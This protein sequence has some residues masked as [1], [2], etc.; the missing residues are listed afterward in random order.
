[1][2]FDVKKLDFQSDLTH[3]N[4][5]EDDELGL[6]A[7]IHNEA[8]QYQKERL[9][10]T[11]LFYEGDKIVGYITVAMDSIKPKL[12]GLRIDNFEKANYPA[13]LLGRL[14]VAN[15]ERGK[16]IG[17]YLIKYC[18]LLALEES[19]RCGC[20]FIVLVTKGQRRIKFYEDNGFKKT[21]IQ[22]KDGLKLMRFN[23][24]KA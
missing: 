4:C 22:L 16:H 1:M 12:S 20:R 11:Y 24:G 10:V 5:N 7:F 17:S 19:K 23:L 2:V 6:H 15:T 14:A 13:L 9:G 18:I 8:L 21:K 3:F